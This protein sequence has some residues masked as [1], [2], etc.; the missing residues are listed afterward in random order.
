VIKFLLLNE[1]LLS[2]VSW[3]CKRRLNQG[4]RVNVHSYKQCNPV[5]EPVK[6][7]RKACAAWDKRSAALP[8][9]SGVRNRHNNWRHY[10]PDS[11]RQPRKVS[12]AVLLERRLEKAQL[13]KVSLAVL[14]E[15]RFKKA[16]Q[17]KE[18]SSEQRAKSV[19]EYKTLNSSDS[20]RSKE[21][22]NP[23]HKRNVN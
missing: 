8:G 15:Q 3:V 11:P 2:Q 16:Q 6:L 21:H 18:A 12:L 23:R 10:V 7:R 13:R 20:L 19:A 4:P 14:L 5:S 22:D 1:G 9:R 17:V